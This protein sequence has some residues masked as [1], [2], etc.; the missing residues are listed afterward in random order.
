MLRH[1]AQRHAV[2]WSIIKDA[3]RNPLTRDGNPRAQRKLEAAIKAAGAHRTN[4]EPG[5]KGRYRLSVSSWVGYSPATNSR[6]AV[7]DELPDKPW[8]AL[9]LFEIIGV[10]P[11]H[12]YHSRS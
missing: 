6:I 9:E 11:S 10:G 12:P 8:V 3:A 7:D 4:L 1:L 2:T 5:K